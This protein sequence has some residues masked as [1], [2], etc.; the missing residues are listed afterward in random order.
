M[1]T[2]LLARMLAIWVFELLM[3]SVWVRA[4]TWVLRVVVAWVSV[5]IR[6]VLLI[7]RLL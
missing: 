3:L 7:I 5:M 4:R 1:L 2:T 6:W